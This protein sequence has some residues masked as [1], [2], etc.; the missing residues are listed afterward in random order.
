MTNNDKPWYLY[1]IR[2]KDDSLYTGITMDIQRRF[3]EHQEQGP[4]SA[5]YLRGK[6]PIELVYNEKLNSKPVAL[7]AE[8]RIKKLS[9]TEKEA[10]VKAQL[11]D[12]QRP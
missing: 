5:K 6:L 7:K 8:L 10:L 11:P 4:R 1:M 12:K 3:A 2:C 9:K